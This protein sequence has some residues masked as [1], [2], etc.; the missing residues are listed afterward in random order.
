MILEGLHE[1]DI[2]SESNQ[3]RLVINTED[4]FEYPSHWHNATELVYV[5]EN[6]YI[7]NVC[8][9]A[10][11][12][13]KGD[14]L[15]ISPGDLHSFSTLVN[16]G[17][18]VFLQFTTSSLCSFESIGCVIPFSSF[19]QKIS[20]SDDKV[21]HQEIESSILSIIDEH[22]KK[23]FAYTLK[24]TSRIY[25]I[26]VALSRTAIKNI[27]IGISQKAQSK[28]SGLEKINKVFQYL[29]ENYQN[30]I[31]LSDVSKA[32]GFSEFYFSRLFKNTMGKNF[33]E[34][35][36]DLRIRKAENLLV[37][38]NMPIAEIAYS[39]GFNSIATFN[40]AFKT[41]KGFPPSTYKKMHI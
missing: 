24:I 28:V 36:M 27:D 20:A 29:E 21:L 1:K 23:D 4:C 10:H 19:T 30:N 31:S 41:I 26:L 37:Y 22:E 7:V 8:N 16:G 14:I 39:V 3:F 35:L 13:N 5:L 18:I 34:Y 25:D 17:K 11:K 32:V 33:H 12:L 40:R 15:I 9:V 38:S 6:S 2:F